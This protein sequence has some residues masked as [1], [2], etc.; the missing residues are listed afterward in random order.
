MVLLCLPNRPALA[1]LAIHPNWTNI[2]NQDKPPQI[3]PPTF[4]VDPC[5]RSLPSNDPTDKQSPSAAADFSATPSS[6]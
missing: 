4:V 2:E 5:L 1:L 3:C 6:T